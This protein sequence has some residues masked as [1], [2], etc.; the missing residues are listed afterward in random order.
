MRRMYTNKNVIDVVNKA[1]ED[2]EIEVGGGDLPEYSSLNI[3]Q[4]LGVTSG[5]G[6]SVILNWIDNDVE[7]MVF[8]R[9]GSTGKPNITEEERNYIISKKPLILIARVDGNLTYSG[10]Y[11]CKN[12][13]SEQAEYIQL[14][15]IASTI[16]TAKSI[17][18]SDGNFAGLGATPCYNF[19]V[20]S[21]STNLNVSAN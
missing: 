15:T 18:K 12:A 21:T 11:Y 14:Q 10:L 6:E 9:D 16:Y 19:I 20:N 3:G 7:I 17:L 13:S 5:E 2:G 1:I 4:I 8:G